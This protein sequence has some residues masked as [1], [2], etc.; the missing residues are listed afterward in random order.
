MHRVHSHVIELAVHEERKV[1]EGKQCRQAGF[2][3]RSFIWSSVV[4]LV[5]SRHTTSPSWCKESSTHGVVTLVIFF[6]AT[7]PR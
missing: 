6:H 3:N 4:T 2:I 1:L 7:S 5:I